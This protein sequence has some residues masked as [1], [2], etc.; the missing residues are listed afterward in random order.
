MAARWCRRGRKGS[1]LLWDTVDARG[2]GYVAPESELEAVGLAVLA[3]GGFPPPVR[4]L[5]LP[6]RARLPGRVDCAYVAERVLIEWDGRLHHL[7]EAQFEI[8]RERDAE[9][10]AHGWLPLRFTW[11]MAH[12][13]QEWIWRVVRETLAIGAQNAIAA[14]PASAPALR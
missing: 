14:A 2:E 6:W 8:D 13:R 9:A 3:A 7:I 11:K 12:R 4:Q 1:R 5:P 10:I